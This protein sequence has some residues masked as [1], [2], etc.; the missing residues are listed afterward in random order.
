MMKILQFLRY[1]M[2]FYGVRN[3]LLRSK[4][5]LSAF[6]QLSINGLA[7]IGIIGNSYKKIGVKIYV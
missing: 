2:K 1:M 7:L 3:N 5:R 6:S 4:K